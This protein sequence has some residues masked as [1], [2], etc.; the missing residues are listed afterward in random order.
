MR[1]KVIFIWLTVVSFFRRFVPI[2]LNFDQESPVYH[3]SYLEYK[4]IRHNGLILRMHGSG[5]IIKRNNPP[6]EGLDFVLGKWRRYYQFNITN[7]VRPGELNNFFQVAH[8]PTTV[9]PLASWFPGGRTVMILR[10]QLKVEKEDGTFE[11]IMIESDEFILR[12]YKK[13]FPTIREDTVRQAYFAWRHQALGE[14]M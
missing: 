1:K 9:P 10:N 14:N 7:S 5:D 6:I 3:D 2:S 11:K 12:Y 13:Y 4:L 8:L